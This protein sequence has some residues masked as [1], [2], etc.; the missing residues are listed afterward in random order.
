MGLSFHRLNQEP[1]PN[2]RGKFQRPIA[3]YTAEWS[4]DDSL[5]SRADRRGSQ[6]RRWAVLSATDTDR[7]VGLYRSW[8]ARADCARVSHS[9]ASATGDK[10]VGRTDCGR[11]APLLAVRSCHL[12]AKSK[13]TLARYDKVSDTEMAR[14]DPAEKCFAKCRS[15]GAM[16]SATQ[17]A[18]GT[19]KPIGVAPDCSCGEGDFYRMTDP[20][21]D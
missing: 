15:C 3:S 11:L 7:R 2:Y 4:L 19:I 1:S 5:G 10:V 16:F 21:A 6:P 17:E 14:S 18:D 13:P 8:T 20:E 9:P 12:P